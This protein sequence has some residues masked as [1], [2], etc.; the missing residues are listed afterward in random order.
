MNSKDFK[1][2]FI[3]RDCIF[4]FLD[5]RF[6]RDST[7]LCS[8][9]W[10]AAYWRKGWTLSSPTPLFHTGNWCPRSSMKDANTSMLRMVHLFK[11]IF[12]TQV[13]SWKIV[14]RASFRW[15]MEGMTPFS[16]LNPS[17]TPARKS[18]HFLHFRAFLSNSA[19]SSVIDWERCVYFYFFQYFTWYIPR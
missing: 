9:R 16:S 1:S 12:A 18:I 4:S 6:D 10:S 14:L 7:L 2:A 11:G 13:E 19:I 15:V 5:R 17:S 3:Q 8:L